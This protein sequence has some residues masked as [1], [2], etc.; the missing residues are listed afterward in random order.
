MT[1]YRLQIRDEEDLANR[2]RD[3]GADMRCLPFF[4]RKRQVLFLMFKDLDFRA[5]NVIKQEMLA[6][7]GDAAVHGGAICGSVERS[8]ALVMGTEGQ[9]R[10]LADKLALMPYF[11]LAEVREGLLMALDGITMSCWDVPLPGGRVLSLNDHTKVMG[12]INLTPDSFFQG[13]RI[14]GVDKCVEAAE[15]MLSQGAE[16]LDLG[17]ESTRPGS[18]PVTSEEELER[19]LPPLR[20][21]RQK[22]PHAIIS[23]DT[24]KSTTA[25]ACS[26]EGADIINDISGLTF[27]PHMPQTA[28]KSGCALVLMHIKGRPKDMQINPSY[29]DL[30][31]EI[32]DFFKTQM[33]VA[34]EAGMPREQIILDPGIGFGKTPDHNLEILRNMEAFSTLGR[35]ILIGAS[36][37]S[38][39]G[40]ATH[41]SDPADR[42]EGTLAITALCAMKGASMVRVHDVKENVKTIMMI[43]AI[44]RGTI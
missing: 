19:L 36:R 15:M 44:R 24:Y 38:T 41:A 4:S 42:L 25:W 43:N 35:P 34:Q 16:V 1:P 26:Q 20:A 9:L 3:I 37:K 11:G 10:S 8:S 6:R 5:A 39:V 7:G 27:D 40:M 30:L 18:D 22:F 17:A 32:A 23:V 31:G 12:I 29:R 33:R 28:A 21:V 13:S 2:L 14:S